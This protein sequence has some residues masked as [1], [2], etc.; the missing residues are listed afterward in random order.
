MKV[1][2][3]HIEEVV[4]QKTKE[5]LLKYGVKGWNMTDLA[6][7]CNMSKRTLYKIIGNKEDLLYTISQKGITSSIARMENYLKSNQAFPVLLNNLSRQ[8]IEGFDEF[9]LANI[10]ALRVDY[11][12]IKEMAELQLKKQHDLFALFFQKGKKEECIVDY[13][14]ASTIQKIIH[15]LIEFHIVNCNNRTEFKNEME[16]VLNMFFKGIVK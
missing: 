15:A 5:L 7:E 13:A 8:I 11:P 9:T 14:E 12:R 6:A 1:G 10:K 2:D 3:I 4:F 16:E